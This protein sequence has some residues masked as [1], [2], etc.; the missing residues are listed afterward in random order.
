MADSEK[1]DSIADSDDDVVDRV[2]YFLDV[3]GS[4]RTAVDAF[5]VQCTCMNE[6]D[7]RVLASLLNALE[8]KAED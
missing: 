2:C 3:F 6:E 1:R 4:P 8:N 7:Q 5:L